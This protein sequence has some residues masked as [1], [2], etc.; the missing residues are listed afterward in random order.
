MLYKYAW[1]PVIKG[2]HSLITC[3]TFWELWL[4]WASETLLQVTPPGFKLTRIN[5]EE[6]NWGDSGLHG[7]VTLVSNSSYLFSAGTS[8]NLLFMKFKGFCNH[9]DYWTCLLYL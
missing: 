5:R 9:L 3:L 1:T 2:A 8:I 4:T 6:A 7:K